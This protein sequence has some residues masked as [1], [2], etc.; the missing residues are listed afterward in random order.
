MENKIE[1]YLI[2]KCS[3]YDRSWMEEDQFI[4]QDITKYKPKG[5]GLFGLFF[6]DDDENEYIYKLKPIEI[7]TDDITQM[8]LPSAEKRVIVKSGD[9]VEFTMEQLDENTKLL[10]RYEIEMTAKIENCAAKLEN[11]EHYHEWIKKMKEDRIFT[12]SSTIRGLGA[13]A[14]ISE[15][16][17]LSVGATS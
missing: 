11:I 14:T 7:V 5:N 15:I 12:C 3:F 13:S 4:T 17:I 8:E 10:E 16:L 2:T 1:W 6:K 9:V